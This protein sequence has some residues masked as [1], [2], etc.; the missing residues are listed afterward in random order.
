MRWLVLGLIVVLLVA[1]AGDLPRTPAPTNAPTAAP[2]AAATET[3]APT[4]V[5]IDP[6]AQ[7]P[8]ATATAAAVS[9]PF[10]I[11][12]SYTGIAGI[13]TGTFRVD[14]ESI[15]VSVDDATFIHEKNG[16]Y[17][18]P[19][20]LISI[21][22]ELTEYYMG[23]IVQMSN[24]APEVL[25]GQTT[26]PG[27][28]VTVHNLQFRIA[29]MGTDPLEWYGLTFVLKVQDL[30][31]PASSDRIGV[32]ILTRGPGIFGNLELPPAVSADE[33]TR[34]QDALARTRD[35]EMYRLT[36]RS[37][38]P[39][40][41]E[42]DMDQAW[43]SVE[44]TS[45]IRF[46]DAQFALRG[47]SLLIWGLDPDH[48]LD[49]I[50]VGG[51]TYVHGPLPLSG[52][53]FD[54]WYDMSRYSSAWF[55][56]WQPVERVVDTLTGH[57]RPEELT[58]AG[59][60]TI[61]NQLCTIFQTGRIA[62][63]AAFRRF[64]GK[65]DQLDRDSIED[66]Y[67]D[68]IVR[69]AALALWVCDDGYVHQLTVDMRATTLET[70]PQISGSSMRVRIS[71]INR[72]I[73]IEAPA[74]A[75]AFVPTRPTAGPLPALSVAATMTAPRTAVVRAGPT[76]LDQEV[77]RIAAGEQVALLERTASGVWYRVR[78]ARVVVGWV[79]VTEMPVAREVASKVPQLP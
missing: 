43:T 59:Q 63:L 22:A 20:K 4:A 36:M 38:Q 67:R 27:D 34:V 8:T 46:D 57:I 77:D 45:T 26:R 75:R 61:D 3:V 51:R 71:D 14:P 68:F 53:S 16:S 52:A 48:G 55:Y 54:G 11:S 24:E 13:I 64:G 28:R 60:E 40:S 2:A 56:P 39:D 73:A 31:H 37:S 62:T 7:A 33:V 78:T 10:K 21:S 74:K 47:P 29:R 6:T 19:I 41:L 35:L 5:Q 70:S 66:T 15:Y 17:K 12:S 23:R 1:C 58:H 72:P 25:L 69:R 50:N 32:I 9:H 42:I 44:Y 76:V 30:D 65:T 49:V 18:E 79:S